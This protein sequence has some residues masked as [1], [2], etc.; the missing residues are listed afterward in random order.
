MTLCKAKPCTKRRISAILRS[1]GLGVWG[2]R[3]VRPTYKD[4]IHEA[5][6]DYVEL[7]LGASDAT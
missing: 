3:M 7:G 5:A 6:P 4:T 2:G 1:G